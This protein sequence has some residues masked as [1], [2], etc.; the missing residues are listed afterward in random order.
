MTQHGGLGVV[1][2][3]VTVVVVACASGGAHPSSTAVMSPFQSG[4]PTVTSPSPTPTPLPSA[5]A[6]S[7]FPV[8]YTVDANSRYLDA[9]GIQDQGRGFL[10]PRCEERVCAR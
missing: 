5:L 3:L 1:A 6:P 2:A 10:L 9:L 4:S 7:A 8:F